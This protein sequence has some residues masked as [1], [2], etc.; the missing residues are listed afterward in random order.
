[1]LFLTLMN[2]LL[3]NKPVVI[4]IG[5]VLVVLVLLIGLFLFF[6]KS[7]SN[8]SNQDQSAYPTQVPIPSISAESIGLTLKLGIPGQTV[9]ATVAN[10]QG[11]SAIDYEF[12]YTAKGNIPRGVFGQFEL[13]KKPVTKEIKL[14]TC[15]D[16]CHYDEDVT[17][18]KIVL[19]VTKED[20]KVYQ[21]EASLAPS[22]EPTP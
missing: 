20:G 14:G 12:S 18:I 5:V 10:T 7:A 1:M 4:A 15:S 2:K 11:I 9:I 8:K 16:K 21:S 17:N 6:N 3:K 22:A 19:K 13:T